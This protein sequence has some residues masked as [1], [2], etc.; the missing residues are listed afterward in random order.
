LIPGIEFKV[1]RG[2][3]ALADLKPEKFPSAAP[4]TK[5]TRPMKTQVKSRMFQ[6]SLGLG[7]GLEG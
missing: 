1:L 5:P 6:E 4:G 7:L 2:L 3:M